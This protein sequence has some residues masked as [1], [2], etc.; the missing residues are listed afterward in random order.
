MGLYT[1]FG[2]TILSIVA[3][4]LKPEALGGLARATLLFVHVAP[5][6]LEEGE[7][8]KGRESP[9]TGHSV[10]YTTRATAFHMELGIA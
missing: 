8:F 10:S 2:D 7:H 9:S 1:S 6:L 4:C 5:V 3:F